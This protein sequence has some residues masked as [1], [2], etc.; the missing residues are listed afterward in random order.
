MGGD[1]LAFSEW[2]RINP[3]A[4]HTHGFVCVDRRTFLTFLLPAS[5]FFLPRVLSFHLITYMP[6]RI[7]EAPPP[8]R[9]RKVPN[10]VRES[11]SPLAD[12]SS[13]NNGVSPHLPARSCADSALADDVDMI[14]TPV[15]NGRSFGGYGSFY[16]KEVKR[17]PSGLL[18]PRGPVAQSRRDQA[19]IS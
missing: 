14:F 16:R 19:T 2:A 8:P 15:A 9:S 1:K 3:L 10:G 12:P 13:D 6:S 7:L 17:R 18:G 4:L 11:A 5:H